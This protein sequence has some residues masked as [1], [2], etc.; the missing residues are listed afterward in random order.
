MLKIEAVLKKIRELL[1][2]LCHIQWSG[3]MKYQFSQ[4]TFNDDGTWTMP[5]WAVERRTKLMN[6]VYSD[7]SEDEKDKDREE[8]DRFL[9]LI[10]EYNKLQSP[11]INYP[12]Y[13]YLN[14]LE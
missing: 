14:R 7:M 2:A 12:R 11:I 4:G 1:A 5:A 6:M 9:A 10:E 8:A 13:D 3:W